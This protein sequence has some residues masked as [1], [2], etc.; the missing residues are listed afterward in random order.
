[1][2]A[3][4]KWLLKEKKKSIESYVCSISE[5]FGIIK[6]SDGRKAQVQVILE[7]DK[8]DWI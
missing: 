7:M 8:D 3:I 4:Q 1:M 5:S 2:Y 6:M